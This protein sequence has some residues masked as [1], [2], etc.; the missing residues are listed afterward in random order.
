[1]ER[2]L[3]FHGN[4]LIMKRNYES[5]IKGYLD[6]TDHMESPRSF[7]LW[8]AL[9]CISG[10]LRGKCWIDMGY[11]KW[12]PN[13]FIIFVAPPGVVQ[14]S[15]T[16]GVGMDLLR[17]VDGVNF[18]PTSATWQ[19]L[20]SKFCECQETFRI[21]Q[22][23]LKMSCLTLECSELGTFLDF[24]DT[25]MIDVI[26][27]MWDGK[28]KPWVRRTRG[29]GEEVIQSPWI[30]LIG[31]TTPSWVREH[32]PEYAIG[33]GFTSRCIFVYGD[34][35]EKLISYPGDSIPADHA[36]KRKKLK[37]DLQN[38]A[39][40]SGT[41]TL[42]DSAKRFGTGWYEDFHTNR[43][44]HLQDERLQGYVA[45]KQTHM[46]KIAICLSASERDDKRITAKH[47]QEALGLLG[48]VE[49]NMGKVF[50]AVSDDPETK[51]LQSI[52]EVLKTLR[53][54]ITRQAFYAMMCNRISLT[55]FDK[56]LDAATQA[57]YMR[58]VKTGTGHM[59]E[60]VKGK[61]YD[62]VISI[63]G[64]EMDIIKEKFAL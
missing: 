61:L 57:G 26:V 63:K 19:A 39:N 50:N 3:K 8:T 38:I 13:Q 33:G 47:L 55:G 20:T 32:M 56:A 53:K 24:R 28:D 30:N 41:F 59:I 11:F 44:G 14:K 23:E 21:G 6:Y 17:S 9:S 10:A 4:I 48:V 25:G 7:H 60:P 16:S 18:G 43:A 40:M 5:F 1:M 58:L 64:D 52:R 22:K 46:H 15:T 45:R 35:K 42:T 2:L 37:E 29:E 31:C 27:D 12:K 49:I 51:G 36:V 34:K 54:P 62:K